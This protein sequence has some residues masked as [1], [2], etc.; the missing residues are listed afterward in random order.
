MANQQTG[1]YQLSQWERTDRIMMEDFNRDN[2]KIDTAIKDLADKVAAE[3]TARAAANTAMADRVTALEGKTGL[4]LLKS[5]KQSTTG[6][7]LKIDVSG[8]DW[9]QWAEVIVVA[10][11]KSS[12]QYK[13][14]PVGHSALTYCQDN[15][16]LVLFPMYQANM[17]VM[18]LLVSQSGATQ[19]YLQRAY[20]GLTEL[21][22]VG[23]NSNQPIAAGSTLKL[24]GR[25]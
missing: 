6:S 9:S 12:I 3:E 22:I 7:T 21:S 19:A 15:S 8:V 24:Y 14:S 13:F 16:M 23:Y 25:K 18:G 11:E 1:N 2:A 4:Q 10:D 5:A 20:S 17:W